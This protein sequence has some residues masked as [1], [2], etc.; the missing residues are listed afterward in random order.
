MK[1]SNDVFLT[2]LLIFSFSLSGLLLADDAAGFV[3]VSVE[4]NAEAVVE[5]PYSPLHTNMSMQ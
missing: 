1:Y 3:R 2:L 4:S 5:M